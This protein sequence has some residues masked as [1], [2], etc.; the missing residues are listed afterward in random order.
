M[1]A[2]MRAVGNSI[3]LTITASELKAFSA[4]AGDIVEIEIKHVV[5]HVREGWEKDELW[6]GAQD[7]PLLLN[8]VADPGFDDSGEWVW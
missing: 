8:D 1:Q 3:G 5:R 4:K 6:Q 2:K 7:E